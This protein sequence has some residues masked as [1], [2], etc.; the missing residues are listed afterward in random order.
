MKSNN[1]LLIALALLL[2]S[3]GSTTKIT[4]A[5]ANKEVLKN[6]SYKSVFIAVLNANV[7]AKNMLENE[8]AFRAKQRGIAATMSHDVFIQSFAKENM[9]KKEEIMPAIEKTGA[10]TIFTVSLLDKETSTRYVPGSTSYYAPFGV[11][12]GYYGG[13]YGYYSTIYPMVYEPGYYTTDRTYYVESNLYDAK[14]EELIWSAQS[15]TLN[16]SDLEQFTKDYI[17]A[18]YE[19][20]IK[21]GVLKSE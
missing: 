2:F 16:P 17:D 18:L 15:K 7:Q 8:L 9:P 4:G 6:N 19:Q 10:E 1:L 11:G 13:F 12:Y 20:M 5:W 14:T 3:C 21:D